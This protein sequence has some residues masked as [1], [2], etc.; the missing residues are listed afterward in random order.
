MVIQTI[1]AGIIIGAGVSSAHPA[2]I[3]AALLV[4]P[5]LVL[6]QR[7]RRSCYRTAAGYYLGALWPLAVGARNFFGPNVPVVLAMAFWVV[8]A[9]LLALPYAMF[10]TDVALHLLWRAPLAV[11]IGIVP[12]LGLIGF[13]SPLTASGLLFPAWSW[14]GFGLSLAGCGLIARYPRF[15]ILSIAALSLAANLL[16]SGDRQPPPDWQAMGT[17]FG[18]SATDTS[19]LCVNIWPRHRFRLR[20]L[21]VQPR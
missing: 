20:L 1:L 13:A 6:R 11:L 19:M 12:P 17:H 9:M 16:Y 8:C 3:I 15:G 14:A 2:G 10:W 7:S 21:P 18:G 4:L 5:V